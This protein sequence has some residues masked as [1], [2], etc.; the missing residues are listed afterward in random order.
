MLVKRN[1][2]LFGINQHDFAI[3]RV[4]SN[5]DATWH[6]VRGYASPPCAVFLVVADISEVIDIEE[7]TVPFAR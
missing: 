1:H 5:F 6:I 2:C 7:T 4:G 3:A